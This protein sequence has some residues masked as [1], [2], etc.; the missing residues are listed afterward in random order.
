M[1]QVLPCGPWVAG[2]GTTGIAGNVGSGLGLSARGIDRLDVGEEPIT[3]ARDGLDEARVLG[4]IA[5]R[6]ANL[7]DCFVE[8]VVKIH[9]R[10]GPE[11]A[12][13]FLP[14]HQFSRFLEQHCQHLERL[15]LQPEAQATFR[16]PAGSKIDFE[17][18]KPQTPGW[19]VGL[20]GKL[21]A[22]Y[23]PNPPA[24]KRRMC[25]RKLLSLF[26]FRGHPVSSEKPLPV[27]CSNGV[28]AM[29]STGQQAVPEERGTVLSSTRARRD[30]SH[31]TIQA[32]TDA[33]EHHIECGSMNP[34]H[35]Q[36]K[37][38]DAPSDPLVRAASV[39]GLPPSK[40][41]KAFSN[42]S[43]QVVSVVPRGD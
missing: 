31:G 42:P 43:A 41:R 40:N 9:D 15:L 10:A 6:F 26:G 25:V 23:C 22:Y 32:K 21:V 4:R 3:A 20:H 8:A 36:L 16:Q 12:A 27:H 7:I 33:S 38:T 24:S 37:L 18:P 2:A 5:E 28:M 17:D 39:G 11:S 29:S 1:R 35:R 13:Q 34:S 14:G 19:F 30:R